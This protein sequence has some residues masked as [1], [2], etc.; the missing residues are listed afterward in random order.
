VMTSGARTVEIMEIKGSVHA[1]GFMM[2]YLPTE[3]ILIEADAFT[4]SAPNSPTPAVINGNHQNLA[5]NITQNG[6]QVA[7]ILPLHG[8]MVDVAEL[9]RAVGK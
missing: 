7:R 2:V 1:Q 9:N 3:K 8:R 4:P 6:L 5:N